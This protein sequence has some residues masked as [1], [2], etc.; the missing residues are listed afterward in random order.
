MILKFQK[1]NQYEFLLTKGY[2]VK[3]L[4]DICKFYKQKKVEI[5]V[6]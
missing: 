5:K 2:N 1:L 4:K 3:Q 6:N